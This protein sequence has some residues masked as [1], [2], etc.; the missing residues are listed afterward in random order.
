MKGELGLPLFTHRVSAEH[1]GICSPRHTQVFSY[2]RSV[3]VEHLAITEHDRIA[4][5]ALDI[6]PY[7]ARKILAE[8]NDVFSIIPRRHCLYLPFLYNLHRIAGI[9]LDGTICTIGKNLRGRPSTIV[10]A[11]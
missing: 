1:I 4:F 5:I 8:V 10:K 3:G 2:Q 11:R 7:D 6:E 9:Q